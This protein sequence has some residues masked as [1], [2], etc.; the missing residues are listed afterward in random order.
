[1][2]LRKA[3][4]RIAQ[5]DDAIQTAIRQKLYGER[6]DGSYPEGNVAGAKAI[7]A[8]ILHGS[9]AGLSPDLLERAVY[10]GGT[11]GLQA[12]A[13]VGAGHGLVTSIVGDQPEPNTLP[14]A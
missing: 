12:G 11:R 1:M 4:E 13:L 10:V 3:G 2:Y 8:S 7:I 6:P 14:L 9:G 5:V